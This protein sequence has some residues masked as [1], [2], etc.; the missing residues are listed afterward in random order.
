ML[1]MVQGH[2]VADNAICPTSIFLRS[3]LQHNEI[4]IYG[5]HETTAIE[6]AP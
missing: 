3:G 6:T 1:A 5:R 4:C 2:V